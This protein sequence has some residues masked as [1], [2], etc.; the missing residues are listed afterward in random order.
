MLK[1]R[2]AV[3]RDSIA[4]SL[5]VVTLL[6][7]AATMVTLVPG[8]VQAQV[9]TTVAGNGSYPSSDGG[10]ATSS[11]IDQPFAV[12]TAPDG[13]F[14][15]TSGSAIRKVDP[16]GI[17]TLIAGSD[18]E[19]SDVGDGGPALEARFNGIESL[20]VNAAGELYI[21]DSGNARVRKIDADGNINTVAGNGL[22]MF[23][24]EPGP[25]TE[26]P[27]RFAHA[28]AFGP[29]GSLF[30]AD[31]S[32]IRKV[33]T[34]G[35][36]T[37]IAGDGS[38]GFEGDYGP[39][40]EA[41][42]S[43][44]TGLAVKADGTLYIADTG[45][46]RLRKIAPDGTITSLPTYDRPR[47]LAISPDD[48]TLYFVA[49]G[50]NYISAQVRETLGGMVIAGTGVAGFS[51]DGAGPTAARIN[52]P[53]GVAVDSLGRM[54][55]ADTLNL[56]VRR[57]DFD[58]VNT[59]PS[60]WIDDPVYATEGDDGTTDVSLGWTLDAPAAGP[61]T[62]TIATQDGGP[63]SHAAAN[64]GIDYVA[65]PATQVTVPA[66]QTSGTIV[67]AVIGDRNVE[68]DQRFT[69]EVTDI[70]GA[71]SSGGSDALSVSVI[72][73]NDDIAPPTP[74]IVRHDQFEVVAS[75][76]ATELLPT[77]NDTYDW[78]SM[79]GGSFALVSAPAHG[80]AVVV[81][82]SVPDPL[83][84]RVRYTPAP[85]FA[86]TDRFRYRLCNGTG[87][88][89]EADIEVFVRLALTQDLVTVGRM[90]NSS[91][92]F[93]NPQPLEGLVF[94]ATPL[95][96]TY[97]KPLDLNADLTPGTPWDSDDGTAFGLF[98]K[99]PAAGEP[100]MRRV[101]AYFHA[102]SSDLIDLY[103]GIDTNGNGRP[104]EAEVICSDG[105]SG[106]PG[107]EF[108]VQQGA[109][110]VMYWV[111][112]HNRTLDLATAYV[113]S[114]D[115]P[116]VAGDGTLVATGP[117]NLPANE[118]GKMW[119]SWRDDDLLNYQRRMGVVRASNSDGEFIG[120]IMVHLYRES[121]DDED[122]LQ[123]VP[124]VPTTLR[125]SPDA[126]HDR[127]YF[128]M[129]A[130]A[131][132]VIVASES[133]A[134]VDFYVAR[135]ETP[136]DASDSGIDAAPGIGSAAVIAN[137]PGGTQSVQVPGTLAP[138][139]WYVVPHNTS[140]A[141]AP[142]LTLTVTVDA[143]APIV[144]SGSY[145]NAGRSGHGLF[146]YPAGNSLAGIWYT[147]LPDGSSTWYYL[148]GLKPGSNGVWTAPV[149][150]SVWYGD[151]NKL[152]TIGQATVT[153][154]GPDTFSFSYTVDGKAGSEPMAALGRG[155]PMLGG[156]P[157][158]L[159]SHWFDP[160]TAGTG[161]SVQMWPNYEFYAAF[162]YD[163]RGIARY[164]LA[165]RN[166]F[167][168]AEATLNLEQMTGFCPTCNRYAAPARANIGTLR[169][170][171]SGDAISRIQVDGIYVNGIPGV[172]QGD[173]VVQP[174][175]GPGT[176]QGCDL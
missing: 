7:S 101:V 56:R 63:G 46:D 156:V 20:A 54:Y 138:G 41:K 45:N 10:Q 104:D 66:G 128:D 148:Q 125:L 144:R 135:Q 58:A 15:F 137:A 85:G 3:V 160:A 14:Y 146:L 162:V 98:T 153:P 158:D 50:K 94:S 26:R 79:A 67:V 47:S 1:P 159:S 21:L 145:F 35:I 124:G 93:S 105:E 53:Y 166:G 83:D 23:S 113:A 61:V 120:D 72:I 147:Y 36:M 60:L 39:A 52:S 28:I 12:A 8:K 38:V 164:L 108:E 169:R 42:L 96:V 11:G 150:R 165:E 130:N 123:L 9:I 119:M 171:L 92:D 170:T 122:A 74:F 173:D 30:I 117:G 115:V 48:R 136:L 110:G 49:D 37:L 27:I 143:V 77:V 97:G 44:P 109:S 65:L 80:T 106:N 161:Y 174:L 64:A 172:W 134:E 68:D 89:K 95:V 176:T 129:P 149:Y 32:S 34:D 59:A 75:G 142:Y 114:F 140:T 24:A 57:V 51:G 43:G 131:T 168:G 90:D 91:V 151:Q 133:T 13:S 40:I 76:P 71:Q 87:V 111:M 155:C 152:T 29:D 112:A 82:E 17:V 25:A 86:G 107:C 103:V 127:I 139:R 6:A 163:A 5:L 19:G 126:T 88:C 141:I 102:R 16:T 175:G 4:S 62:F 157:Q 132:G 154:T 55:I 116:L 70:V 22:K 81:P 100:I 73:T 118:A 33:G 31:H 2:P 84:S 78:E 18:S 99:Q 121:T 69:V 167:G